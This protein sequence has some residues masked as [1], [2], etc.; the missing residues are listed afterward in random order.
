MDT[1][2]FIEEQ[3][4]KEAEE[5]NMYEYENQSWEKRQA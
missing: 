4:K 1:F 2:R 3:N 5:T